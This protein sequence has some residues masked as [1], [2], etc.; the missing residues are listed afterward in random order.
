MLNFF[1]FGKKRRTRRSTRKTTRR[2]RRKSGSKRPPA[3]LLRLCRR[4][5]VKATKKVGRRR[6][7]KSVAVLKRQCAKKAR[8]MRKS[9]FGNVHRHHHKKGSRTHR[10]KRALSSKRAKYAGAALLAAL[11]GAGAYKKRKTIARHGRR[12]RWRIDKGYRNK[13]HQLAPYKTSLGGR[14]GALEERFY[15][16][17][18]SR[19][20]EYNVV[21][22]QQMSKFG[23]RRRSRRRYGFGD[24]GNPSLGNSMGYEFCAGGGGVLGA[25]STGL[26]PSPCMSKMGTAAFGKRR[27][28]R[29]RY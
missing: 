27:R 25:N 17:P 2:S 1:G 15:S 4:Y 21:G 24:G 10:I 5:K 8:S 26:F 28:S 13:M 19:L 12:M 6:L 11:A 18:S 22:N 3:K 29:R 16:P 14:H 23:K 7:Y 20:L 9:R